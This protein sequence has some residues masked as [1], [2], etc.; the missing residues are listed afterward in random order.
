MLEGKHISKSFDETEVLHDVDITV[1]PGK[2]T[3][4]I[5]PSG[6]GKSTLLRALALLD[7]PDS[8]TVSIDET[9]YTFPLKEDEEITPPWPHVT[10]VFQ[11]LFLW[12]HM[13]LRRNITLP[14]SDGRKIQHN[15]KLD[16]LIELFDMADFI[17][18]Y[19]NEASIGQRQR[20]AL[21]RA[22]V[23][24]PSYILLDE[25][26][27][28]LDVEQISK[29]LTYLQALRD[30]GIGILIITHLINFA[31]RAAD[32]VVFL[33]EGYALQVG[34]PEVLDS[35]KSKR[36]KQFLSVIEAAT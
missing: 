14:V 3:V 11:Q 22:L 27:S 35:P 16:E 21:A 15:D 36:L 29:I 2:I 4:L 25:I 20:V 30:K 7:P 9:T 6:S 24:N 26:T 17:D 8:G 28:A 19:P 18:R 34:G 13:T 31:R 12:P 10:A 32:H 5:G 23:L 33:D 1:E